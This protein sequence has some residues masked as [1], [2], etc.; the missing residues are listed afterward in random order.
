MYRISRINITQTET[1]SYS[2][3]R[4]A[5]RAMGTRSSLR[6]A[7]RV[8]YDDPSAWRFAWL[9]AA[10]L[11]LITVSCAVEEHLFKFLPDFHFYW[12]TAL[13]ELL[14][15]AAY[16][17]FSLA[18]VPKKTK[19]PV[20]LYALT[21][22]CLALSQSLGK[23]A[24]KYLNYATG[25][26]LKSAKLV[27][28]LAISVVWLK[29]SVTPGEWAAAF[30]LVTSAAL[31][32]LGDTAVEPSFDVMGLVL[33]GVNLALAAMQGNLQERCLKD[34]DASIME[35][36]LFTNGFGAALIFAIMLYTG[37][38]SAAVTYF[39]DD[40]ATRLGLLL[41]RS[42]TFLAG[43]VA[44]NA[45]IKQ[46]GTGA[47]TAVGTARKSLTVMLSLL[48]FPKPFH[49]NYAGGV[50]TFIAADLLFLWLKA[51]R[52]MGTDKLPG[53]PRG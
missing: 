5:C 43:A 8:V 20:V 24:F 7:L 31:M 1:T 44:F 49:V 11:L 4:E 28:T 10:F 9:S 29:R 38:A 33:S 12:T 32:A 26:V 46:F 40:V 22:V 34:H 30:L 27:P 48:V 3:V 42:A 45:L 53:V 36:M 52:T 2:T 35:A 16:A 47:A 18:G 19:A 6:A 21:A 51:K 17:L 25:T 15:F 50:V 41:V 39:T 37:E 14:F 23:V 13:V